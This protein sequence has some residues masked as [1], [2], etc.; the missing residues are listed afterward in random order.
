MRLP[1]NPPTNNLALQVQ[2]RESLRVCITAT[3]SADA[4]GVRRELLPWMQYHTELGAAHFYVS[5]HVEPAT[6]L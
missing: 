1:P 6:A 5:R 3:T 2:A 4:M